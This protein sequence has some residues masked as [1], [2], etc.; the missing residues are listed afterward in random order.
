MLD[1]HIT[2]FQ[3]L[4][5]P[6]SDIRCSRDFYARLGFHE[7]MFR[8]IPS[9]EG[10]VLI[11][12]LELNGFVLEL[13]QLVGA[14]LEEIKS[15]T[16]GHIDHFALDVNDINAAFQA[17]QDADLPPLEDAPVF[18]PFWD[19]GVYYFNIQGPDGEKI[20]FNQRVK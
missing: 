1:D 8:E 2:G 11:S 9:D 19:K 4:G 18:L 13:F 16:H 3:H 5:L 17:V 7:I 20:E 15:R 10:T 14:A 12:M 6:V